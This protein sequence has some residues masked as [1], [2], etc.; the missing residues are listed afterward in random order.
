MEKI[1]VYGTLK[2]WWLWHKVMWKAWAQYIKDDYI[3]IESIRNV[4]SQDSCDFGHEYPHIIF[5]AGTG[6][7]VFVEVYEVPC[8][9]LI[10]HVDT[11]EEY[12]WAEGDPYTRKK[13]HTQSGEELWVYDS[14]WEI[15]HDEEDFFTWE[16]DSHRYYS[17]Q[18]KN[19]WK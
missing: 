11:L 6:K 2:K 8:D 7:Y 13:I 16:K 1:A 9:S 15:I 19:L 5:R 17:W 3:E 18:D 14:N 10:K 4:I 12:T